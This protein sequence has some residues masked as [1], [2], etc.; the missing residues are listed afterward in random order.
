MVQLYPLYLSYFSKKKKN[1]EM[2][3]E[4]E[5]SKEKNTGKR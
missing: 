5:V 1:Q 3:D 2:K 4:N